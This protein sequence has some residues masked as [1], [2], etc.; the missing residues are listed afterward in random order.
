MFSKIE[1][2]RCWDENKHG[3]QVISE[4]S[5]YNEKEAFENNK[6]L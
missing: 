1:I 5:K 2:C 6:L 3:S 4:T